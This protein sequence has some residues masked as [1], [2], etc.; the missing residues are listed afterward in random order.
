MSWESDITELRERVRA[1]SD[2]TDLAFEKQGLNRI[3]EAYLVKLGIDQL[4]SMFDLQLTE[5]IIKN[6]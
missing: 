4:L 5:I 3:P 2:Q 6:K 1:A